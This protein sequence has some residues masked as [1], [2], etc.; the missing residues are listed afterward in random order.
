MTSSLSALWPFHLVFVAIIRVPLANAAGS[1]PDS[2]Y[3]GLLEAAPLEA[4]QSWMESIVQTKR[5]LPTSSSPWLHHC[6]ECTGFPGGGGT[7]CHCHARPAAVD[8]WRLH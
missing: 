4:S 1:V 6:Q 3:E 7:D 5:Q 2:S 8:S